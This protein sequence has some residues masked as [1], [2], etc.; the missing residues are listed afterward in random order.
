MNPYYNS[1]SQNLNNR[2]VEYQQ[3]QPQQFQ[4]FQPQQQTGY[5]TRRSQ[6]GNS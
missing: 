2:L 3:Y 5:F 6:R 4:Q 1:F